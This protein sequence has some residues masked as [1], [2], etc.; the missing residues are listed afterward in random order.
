VTDVEV[1]GQ[2]SPRGPDPLAVPVWRIRR[3]QYRPRMSPMGHQPALDGLRAVAVGA[4]LVYHARFPWAPG[5]FLGVSAFFTLSGFLITSLVLREWSTAGAVDVRRFLRRRFRRLLPAS[6]LTIAV[7][8][9]MGFAG[10]WSTEQLRSL[11][12]DVPFALLEILNWHFVFQGRS[13]GDQFAAPSPLEHFWSLAVEQQFYLVFPLLVTGLLAVGVRRSRRRPLRPLAVGLGVL[14]VLA[15]LANAVVARG[16]VF[17]AYFST[18]TRLAELLIGALLAFPFLG[19]LRLASEVSRRVVAAL[20][21]LGAVVSVW[22]WH[23]AT[24]DAGWLYPWGLLVSAGATA[25]VIAVAVQGGAATAALSWRPLVRVGELSYG[26]YLLHW[27][28]FLW[29]TPAR[30]GWAPWPLF[31][32]RM[33]VTLAGAVLMFRFVEHPIRT[34]SRLRGRWGPGTAPV[35][36]V[37]LLVAVAVLTADL[38]APRALAN[39]GRAEGDAAVAPPTPIRVMVIGDELASGTGDAFDVTDGRT[40]MQVEALA[41]PGCGLAVGGTV[42]LAGGAVER[43]RDRC[44]TV[45]DD[46][47]AAVTE[48]RPDVVVVWA[49]LRDVSDRRFSSAEPW[50]RPGDPVLDDF[51]RADA[52]DLLDRLSATGARVVVLS[53]PPVRNTAELPPVAPAPLPSDPAAAALAAAEAAG[54][55]TDVPPPGHAENDDA[56]IV[57]WNE[58]LAQVAAARGVPVLDVAGTMSGWPGGVL[59]PERRS[60]GV[61]L[62]PLGAEEVAEWLAPL[63]REAG[64]ASV[65]AAPPTSLDP[66]APLPPAPPLTPRRT[67]PPGRPAR[68]LVVGDSVAYNYGYGLTQWA[69]T[70]RELRPVNA[71]QLGCAVARGGSYRYERDIRDF[72]ENCDW[73]QTFPRFLIEQNPDVV[74]LSS[75]IWEVVDRRLPGEDR[76]RTVGD[77]GVDRYLL[78]EW[79]GAVDVLAS[80]GASVVLL[81][82]PHFEAG[83]DQG[84]SDLP[85]SDPERVDRLNAIIREVALQRPGVTTLVDLQAWLAAQPGGELDPAKRD[86]GLHFR[87]DYSVVIADWLGPQLLQVARNGPPPST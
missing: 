63:L 19:G 50:L 35:A 27:P 18:P 15:A 81:T 25:A 8:V 79:L 49:G 37:G 39:V 54:V 41:R 80:G 32:L 5:G 21:A 55:A 22:L 43:D 23:T 45:R 78:A 16:D 11:R 66:A 29:L 52:A 77:P 46:W 30:V 20:G 83:K 14:A 42:R 51:L 40:P 9:A 1:V 65:A 86:D 36:A 31:A 2:S 26:I 17:A 58:L 3:R 70:N 44:G 73:S 47:V 69:E 38:P 82:Y 53:V 60:G 56:R 62:T 59:D 10:V 7:V 12:G 57:A 61:G 76:F 68:V 74:V 64:T 4:V 28:V 71:S 34:G 75:G 13:Y 48:Q 24:V 84:F 87:D 72:G 6:W 33:A 85:E 67:V